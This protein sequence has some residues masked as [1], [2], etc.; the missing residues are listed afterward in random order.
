MYVIRFRRKLG[1]GC[2]KEIPASRH[3]FQQFLVM[4]VECAAQFNGALHK[5]IVRHEGIRPYRLDQFLLL[6]ESPGM[7]H[8]VFEGLVY[9][10]PELDLRAGSKHTPPRDIQ[11]ELAELIVGGNRFQGTLPLRCAKKPET[12][13]FGFSLA[14]FRY[15][16]RQALLVCAGQ[17]TL[18]THCGALFTASDARKRRFAER[19]LAKALTLKKLRGPPDWGT[20]PILQKGEFP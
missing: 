13:D 10:W 6:D 14:F 2:R 1:D 17:A 19:I 8:K 16:T 15:F 11:Q 7:L 9:L 12:C 3:S 20:T 4:I 18:N 5:R